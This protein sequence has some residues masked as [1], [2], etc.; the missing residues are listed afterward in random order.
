MGYIALFAIIALL[1]ILSATLVFVFKDMLHVVLSFSALFIINSAIFMVLGQPF[2]ALL[3]L[4][5]MVGGVSTY[6]FVGV[7]SEATPSSRPQTTRCL[8]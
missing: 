7:A 4:F 3:Q 8:Q 5:I 2:L 6:L 1:E